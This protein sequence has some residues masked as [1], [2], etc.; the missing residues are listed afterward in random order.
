M[1]SHL[2]SVYFSLVKVISGYV[3]LVQVMSW[4]VTIGEFT[5]G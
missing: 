2:R 4:L 1:L 5:S 3:R